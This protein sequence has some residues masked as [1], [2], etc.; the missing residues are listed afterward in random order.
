MH[1][2]ARAAACGLRAP[3]SD[4][5]FPSLPLPKTQAYV[6][7]PSCRATSYGKVDCST[8]HM[9]MPSSAATTATP[10]LVNGLIWPRS[11]GGVG[12]GG[13]GGGVLQKRKI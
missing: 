9:K 13:G 7:T 11:R 4:S 3:R 2:W 12:G 10:A 8:F 6:S 5:R 1:R